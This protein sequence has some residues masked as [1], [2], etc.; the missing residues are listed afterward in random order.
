MQVQAKEHLYCKSCGKRFV[1]RDSAIKRVDAD[2][3]IEWAMRNYSLCPECCK[4][5]AAQVARDK[6]AGYG[7]PKIAGGTKKQIDLAVM[8]RDRYIDANINLFQQIKKYVTDFGVTTIE[9]K[10]KG[11]K[12]LE[13]M[14]SIFIESNSATIISLLQ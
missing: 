5:D 4:K 10:T 2:D 14:C 13:K 6:A 12:P 9:T 11:D 1:F 7:L 8:L 3:F